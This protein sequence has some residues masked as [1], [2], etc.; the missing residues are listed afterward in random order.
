M[1]L[2]AQLLIQS[3]F[4]LYG[5]SG[6]LPVYCRAGGNGLDDK[7]CSQVAEA[8]VVIVSA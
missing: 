6:T 8:E 5:E 1:V 2:V 7:V 4:G 3:R